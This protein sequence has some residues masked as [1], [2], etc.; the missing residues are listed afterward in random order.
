MKPLE[1]RRI[2]GRQTMDTMRNHRG[3]DVAVVNLLPLDS[4]P[5]DK[6]QA[7]ADSLRI[8]VEQ[9]APSCP[10][11]QRADRLVDAENTSTDR[12][13]RENN[14]E[15]A[16][17]LR[18]D[19]RRSALRHQIINKLARCFVAGMYLDRCGDDKTGVEEHRDIGIELYF[20]VHRP[21]IVRRAEDPRRPMP[22]LRSASGTKTCPSAPEDARAEPPRP[23]HVLVPLAQALRAPAPNAQDAARRR[24]CSKA[25]RR[26]TRSQAPRDPTNDLSRS[27]RPDTVGSS[28]APRAGR[29]GARRDAPTDAPSVQAHAGTGPKTTA[30]F[31]VGPV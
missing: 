2:P 28:H 23:Q 11:F 10:D 22:S 15:L 16:A 26:Q 30:Q 19:A 21:H 20:S 4:V 12:L 17:D 9:H 27:R 25:T 31:N 13:A 8:F 3:H 6:A 14:E 18:T 7:L 29:P 5:S 1:I 24:P